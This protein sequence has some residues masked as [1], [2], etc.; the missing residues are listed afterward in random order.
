MKSRRQK[1]TTGT[2]SMVGQRA[3]IIEWNGTK[4]QVSIQGEL[5]QAQSA[6]PLDIAAGEQVTVIAVEGLVLKVKI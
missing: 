3:Q 5:W 2:E 1:I 6:Q 4:G